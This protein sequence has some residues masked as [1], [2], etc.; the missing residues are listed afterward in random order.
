MKRSSL[1]SESSVHICLL[2]ETIESV[3]HTMAEMFRK[4]RPELRLE[5]GLELWISARQMLL[6]ALRT[7]HPEWTQRE[8]EQEAARRMLRESS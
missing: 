6:D 4:I 8:V 5:I 2:P 7:F 1:P 3:D